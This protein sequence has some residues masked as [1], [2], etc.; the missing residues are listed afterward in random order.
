MGIE[1][2]HLARMMKMLNGK[3]GQFETTD[4]S[5]TATV[6]EENGGILKC[7]YF[8]DEKSLEMAENKKK[9]NKDI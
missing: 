6:Y 7:E 5:I 3:V 4:N 1:V 9:R 8:P 2:H